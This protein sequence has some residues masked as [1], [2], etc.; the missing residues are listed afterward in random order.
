VQYL[1]NAYATLTALIKEAQTLG[2]TIAAVIDQQ[3]G[4]NV[5]SMGIYCNSSLTYS[6]CVA[7]MSQN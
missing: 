4:Y 2:D 3:S 7:L 6:E 5:T 1:T